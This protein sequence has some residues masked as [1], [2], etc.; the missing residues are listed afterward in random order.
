MASMMVL[1]GSESQ[2]REKNRQE[3]E[4]KWH[5]CAVSLHEYWSQVLS[6]SE[7]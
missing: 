1:A 3:D 6:S 4:K 5:A 2:R 7:K